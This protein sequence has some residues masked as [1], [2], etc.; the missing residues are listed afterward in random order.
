M[1]AANFADGLSAQELFN[2]GEGLTYKYVCITIGGYKSLGSNLGLRC[3]L[4]NYCTRRRPFFARVR[5]LC[6][7]LMPIIITA[8]VH[9]VLRNNIGYS[10]WVVAWW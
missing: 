9:H 5:R 7:V 3:R 4:L 1:A 2:T 6:P 10:C 8:T